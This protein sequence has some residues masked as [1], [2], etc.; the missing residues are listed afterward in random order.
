MTQD[1]EVTTDVASL[2]SLPRRDGVFGAARDS[3]PA[4]GLAEQFLIRARDSRIA[5]TPLR[6]TR[7]RKVIATA[8]RPCT[9]N[10]HAMAV[11][12]H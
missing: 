1:F 11:A 6:Q 2:R 10:T 12:P 8:T 5:L 4:D 9:R 3:W 7:P